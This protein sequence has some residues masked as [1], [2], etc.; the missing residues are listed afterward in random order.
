METTRYL[1]TSEIAARLRIS[2]NAV[3]RLCASG[4]IEA[5]RFGNLWRVTEDALRAY[6]ARARHRPAGA[7][8]SV[9]RR[10][11]AA[12][13]VVYAMMAERGVRA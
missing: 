1:K 12:R 3:G 9:H 10:D 11:E 5:S 8:G 6:E 13:A 2:V 7:V 4:A